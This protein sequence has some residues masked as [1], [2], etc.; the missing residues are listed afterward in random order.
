VTNS[1]D[2]Y[3]ILDAH[4]SRDGEHEHDSDVSDW[5]IQL[6]HALDEAPDPPHARKLAASVLDAASPG[7]LLPLAQ[8]NPTS[9]CRILSGLC[10]V[11]PFFAPYLI[12]HPE[13]LIALLDQDL[14]V[15]RSQEKLAEEFQRVSETHSVLSPEEIFRC[16]KYFELARITVRDCSEA[17]V[18][19]D[20][21][22]ITLHELSALAD[23]LLDRSMALAV[24]RT[25]KALIPPSWRD[26]GGSERPLRFC[27]LALGK[28]GAME[29][30]YSSDVDLVY[31]HESP[32][33]DTVAQGSE[34]GEYFAKLA[35]EFGAIVSAK[36]F[37]GFLYRVDLEL[38]PN[39]NQGPLVVS[40]GALQ[41]YYESW[42]DR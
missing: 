4:S 3:S 42:A 6:A 19:L 24:G 20:Q 30:N 8:E 22:D 7:L 41:S 28:L 33:E 37:E 29:L 17:W 21:S 34:P 11:A 39:G 9:L 31:F 13:W 27:V 25:S 2:Y 16:F 14:S 1:I 18:P 15:A 38:R 5:L 10:G 12:R 35:R 40:Q 36:T 23:L 32:P 26:A